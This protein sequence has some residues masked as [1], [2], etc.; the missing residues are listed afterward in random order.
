[1]L[2]DIK[3]IFMGTPEFSTDV[4]NMLIANTTALGVITQPDKLVGRKKEL[5]FSPVKKIALENNIKVFQPVKIRNEY[6]DILAMKPDII[7]TAAYGQIIPKAI[8]GCINVHGSLLP[9][10]RGGAPIQHAIIDG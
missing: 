9:K 2:K 4:L 10:L 5:V 6:E 8:L 3:V 1:M 7:I